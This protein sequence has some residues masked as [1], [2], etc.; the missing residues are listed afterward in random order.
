MPTVYE[1]DRNQLKPTPGKV[2]DILYKGADRKIRN[3]YASSKKFLER[4]GAISDRFLLMLRINGIS[5]K[6]QIRDFRDIFYE[7]LPKSSPI[8]KAVD[9]WEKGDLFVVTIGSALEE[10][11]KR[12]TDEG[13]LTD[14]LFLDA[15][16]SVLV[17]EAADV[18]QEIW[19]KNIIDENDFK[20]NYAPGRYSPGYCEWDVKA[21]ETLFAYVSDEKI[22][23]S[24]TNGGMMS[25]RKSI[26][27]IMVMERIDP[28]SPLVASC[29]L[30][31]KKC[32]YMRVR[33]TDSGERMADD[34]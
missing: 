10:S 26:S 15:M 14:A 31:G 8:N 27:G 24:L 30:C 23:V 28:R 7:T 21:Q 20:G 11:V 9:F 2:A 12:L 29:R 18:M 5:E 33:M 17:E 6:I 32:E 16:G 34:G 3:K 1:I 22:P 25:P 19:W 4:Y 13:K